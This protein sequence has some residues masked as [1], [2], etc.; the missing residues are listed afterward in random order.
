M[1]DNIVDH[2][3][4]I[5]AMFNKTT[6]TMHILVYLSPDLIFL[7]NPQYQQNADENSFFYFVTYIPF[8]RYH[9]FILA[10]KCFQNNI[11]LKSLV[12]LSF[13]LGSMLL[14]NYFSHIHFEAGATKSLKY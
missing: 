12:G 5:T 7:I 8:L 4:S 9:K 10:R 3:I 11:I 14:K 1:Y 6:H 13:F 2:D